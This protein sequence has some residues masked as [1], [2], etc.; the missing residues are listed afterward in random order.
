ME[1]NNISQIIVLKESNYFGI[2]HIHDILK[3]GLV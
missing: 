1:Q 3:E 2:V